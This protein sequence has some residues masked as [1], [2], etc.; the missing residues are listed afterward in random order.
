MTERILVKMKRIVCLLLVLSMLLSVTGCN[1]E[2]GIISRINKEFERVGNYFSGKSSED[3]EKSFIEKIAPISV[4]GKFRKY[5]VSY[6]GTVLDKSIA[7]ISPDDVF[8]GYNKDYYINN[9]ISQINKKKAQRYGYHF[10]GWSKTFKEEWELNSEAD[11]LVKKSDITAD[12]IILYPVWEKDVYDYN[13]GKLR[14]PDSANKDIKHSFSIEHTKT[15]VNIVC[16][17]GYTISNQTM[18]LETFVGYYT[19]WDK[20]EMIRILKEIDDFNNISDEKTRNKN[21]SKGKEVTW[22]YALYC[23]QNYAPSVLVAYESIM[24][25]LPEFDELYDSQGK[26]KSDADKKAKELTRDIAYGVDDILNPDDYEICDF[27]KHIGNYDVP[28]DNLFE[29]DNY[30]FRFVSPTDS[31]LSITKDVQGDKFEYSVYK[32][33]IEKLGSSEATKKK[34]MEELSVGIFSFRVFQELT[35]FISLCTKA[36]EIYELACENHELA[37]EW[38]SANKSGEL[39][40]QVGSMIHCMDFL[41][42]VLADNYGLEVGGNLMSQYYEAVFK[43]ADWCLDKAKELKRKNNKWE[44]ILNAICNLINNEYDSKYLKNVITDKSGLSDYLLKLWNFY[45]KK[46]IDKRFCELKLYNAND[47]AANAPSSLEVAMLFLDSLEREAGYQGK[48]AD[49]YSVVMFY[50]ISKFQMEVGQFGITVDEYLQY[51]NSSK[52]KS[53]GIKRS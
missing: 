7:Y 43:T 33:A 23:L 5:P 24:K 20:A 9:I 46:D 18:S 14:V 52:T 50:I 34:K 51:I 1:D 21:K 38:D 22:L 15:A 13:E 10:M 49:D 2:N 35:S 6:S 17:C 16:D 27:R 3:E 39:N 29:N 28:K 48:T 25:K 30:F 45:N 44:N 41:C 32:K 4:I 12:T 37:C 31:L 19:N 42:G 11:Y 8:W 26:K 47:K 53:Y 40:S 36:S